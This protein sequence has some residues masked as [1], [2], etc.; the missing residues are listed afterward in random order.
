MVERND[1]NGRKS[2]EEEASNLG[3]CELLKYKGEISTPGE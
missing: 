2:R 3:K 1:V